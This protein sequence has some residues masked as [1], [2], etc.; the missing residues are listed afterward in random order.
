MSASPHYL[1]VGNE[2]ARRA[3]D[4]PSQNNSADTAPVKSSAYR[5]THIAMPM[6]PPMDAIRAPSELNA[7]EA[8]RTSCSTPDQ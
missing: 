1:I 6:P 4:A 2:K 7:P 8:I 3:G 5:S